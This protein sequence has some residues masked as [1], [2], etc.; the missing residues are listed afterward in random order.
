MYGGKG[1]KPM[2]AD[3]KNW[4]I[5]VEGVTAE[6]M[7]DLAKKAGAYGLSKIGRASCRERV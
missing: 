1:E 7:K 6:D 5:T 2:S 3:L 4:E